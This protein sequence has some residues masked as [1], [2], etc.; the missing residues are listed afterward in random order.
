MDAFPDLFGLR[1]QGKAAP[2][3]P[4]SATAYSAFDGPLHNSIFHDPPLSRKPQRTYGDPPPVYDRPVYD[5][6]VFDGVPGLSGSNH[7]DDI[8]GSLGAAM[9]ASVTVPSYDDLLGGF[10]TSSEPGPGRGRGSIGLDGVSGGGQDDLIPGFGGSGSASLS[11]RENLETNHF[12][13]SFIPSTTSNPD[14]IEDPFVVLESTSAPQS[15]PEMYVDPWEHISAASRS[16]STK[17]DDPSVS[18]GEFDNGNA[19]DGLAKS[20]PL[21]TSEI[22]NE[23]RDKSPLRG[24][25][26]TSLA[27][28]AKAKED[29]ETSSAKSVDSSIPNAAPVDRYQ[30]SLQTFFDMPTGPSNSCESSGRTSVC[31]SEASFNHHKTNIR[32]DMSPKSDENLETNDDTWLPVSEIPL[33]TQPTS[34]LPPLRPPPPLV[35]KQE[36]SLKTDKPPH[37]GSNACKKGNEFSYLQPSESPQFSMPVSDSVN[38]S[39][40][41]S[42][43]ELEDFAMGRSRFYAAEHEHIQFTSNELNGNFAAA[44]SVVAMKAA[45]DR[46]E[47]KIKHANKVRGREGG[48]KASTSRDRQ[49][50]DEK[51]S[52]DAQ[53]QEQNE[54]KE[55][56]EREMRERE[57]KEIERKRLERE[58]EKQW[59]LE[60]GRERQAVE[61]ATRE[62]RGRAAADSLLRAEKQAV[63]RANAAARERA[64][65]AAVQRRVVAE[66][67][68]R[69]AA[70]AAA[71]G[72]P[73]KYANEN[74]RD[75]FFGGIGAQANSAPKQGSTTLDPTFNAQVNNR[76][77]SD[78]TCRTSSGNPFSMRKTSSTTTSVDEFSFLFGGAPSS[79]EFQE[80]EG[81]PADR[82]RARLER[83]QKTEERAAK[84][85][86]EKNERDLQIQQ[87]QEERDRIGMTLDGDIKRWAAG[88]EGNLR[89]LLS[90]L[91]YW[92]AVSIENIDNRI[93]LGIS[94]HYTK[95]LW[96]E[97]DWKPVPLTDLIIAASVK[98]VYRKATLILHPDK[99]QQK[100]AN[101]HQKCIAEHVFELLKGSQMKHRDKPIK[102]GHKAV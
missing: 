59:K 21:F 17:I 14:I 98:K 50:R 6:D 30:E 28:S 60:R 5:D 75:S 9:A 81:E 69:A 100:G 46:A 4:R 13:A 97:C 2:M 33:F 22:K 23:P 49:E 89:A 79:G 58:R 15:S 85:L 26:N 102:P 35:I 67:R 27:N 40:V 3:S 24:V 53:E 88:K 68:D 38:S 8:F 65:R 62:A 42:M 31:P 96:P 16:K 10:G 71:R 45:M 25:R 70:A 78:G 29:L 90:T 41:S 80:N 57:V 92:R 12:K 101:L 1:P 48:P 18:G 52:N 76:G 32:V 83:H 11:K 72:K 51:A 36:S 95:V 44:A 43:D 37:A 73:Q 66:A 20:V 87:D 56:L 86:A 61:R 39:G 77:G 54:R 84:A 99:V 64:G 91:Q 7:E 74:D 93:L 82:Q 63:Q 94:S 47:A 19:F 55:K 34:S